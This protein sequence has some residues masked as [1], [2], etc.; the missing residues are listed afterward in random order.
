[1]QLIVP[2]SG[3][4]QRFKEAGYTKPKPLIKVEEKTIINHVYDMFPQVSSIFF[5]CN[6]N[7]L[8]DRSLNME[9][10]I[11]SFSPETFNLLTAIVMISLPDFF[12]DLFNISI[13]G[14]REVPIINLDSKLLPSI[15]NLSIFLSTCKWDNNLN[16]VI[17]RYFGFIPFRLFD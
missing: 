15:N 8:M 11:K 17:F 1:M 10:Q 13:F 4:G 12:K 3:I 9:A 2:M 6:K 16:T 7:H 14:K 5:I